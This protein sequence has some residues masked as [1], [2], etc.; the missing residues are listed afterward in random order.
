MADVERDGGVQDNQSGIFVMYNCARL[1]ALI[2]K[3]DSAVRQ[4]KRRIFT[5]Y[6]SIGMVPIC[7]FSDTDIQTSRNHPKIYRILF[8]CHPY[9]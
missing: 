6:S 1:K 5:G 9:I 3:Y 8:F 4:G 2:A 7:F